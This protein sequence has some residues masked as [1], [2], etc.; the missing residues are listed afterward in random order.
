MIVRGASAARSLEAEM[1]LALPMM[2]RTML[3]LLQAAGAVALLSLLAAAGCGRASDPAGE[4]PP[5]ATM[6]EDEYVEHVAALTIAVE[7]GLSGEEARARVAELGAPLY[8]REEVE[9]FAEILRR[10]PERWADVAAR[11]DVRIADLRRAE[12][13]APTEADDAAPAANEGAR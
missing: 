4:V 11:L 7:D 13:G 12:A 3:R 6:N 10:D 9:A 5:P 1:T 2:R 8:A